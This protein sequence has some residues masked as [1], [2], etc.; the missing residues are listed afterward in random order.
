VCHQSNV[1]KLLIDVGVYAFSLLNFRVIAMNL[2]IFLHSVSRSSQM[3][4][5]KSELQY[6]TPFWNAML[7]NEDD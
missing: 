4:L 3:N 5:L 1:V 7:K 2:T 6:Y